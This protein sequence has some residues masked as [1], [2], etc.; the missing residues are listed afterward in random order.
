MLDP[1]SG[2]RYHLTAVIPPGPN[3][4]REAEKVRTR[5]LAQADEQR[6]ARTRATV[7]QLMD[8][9]LEVLD[10]E[11]TARVAHRC[12]DNHIRPLLGRL[13]LD[14]VDGEVL[15][16]S[17]PGFGRAAPIAA[18]AGH[19]HRAPHQPPTRVGQPLPTTSVQAAGRLIHPPDSRDPTWISQR[20]V[21]RRWIGTNP[22][23]Q[24]E[25]PARRRP[26]QSLHSCVS[27]P[28]PGVV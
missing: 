18:V 16:L 13:R 12:I 26:I 2:K 6:S 8:R 17:T 3:A 7:N 25:A 20:A 11:R 23:G 4:A 21:R 1:P 15:D 28:D 24:A 27:V 14:K 10:V 19:V 22:T 9:Y 5:L